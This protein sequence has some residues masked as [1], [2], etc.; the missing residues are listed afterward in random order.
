MVNFSAIKLQEIYFLPPISERMNRLSF[1]SLQNKTKSSSDSDNLTSH[2]VKENY[3]KQNVTLN[4]A[5]RLTVAETSHIRKSICIII[6][7]DVSA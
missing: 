5:Q 7:L 3:A 2:F 6:L 1:S 4:F